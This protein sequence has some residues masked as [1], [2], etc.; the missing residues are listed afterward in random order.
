MEQDANS[1]QKKQLIDWQHC[2]NQAMGNKDLAKELL[3]K[4]LLDLPT[5]LANIQQAFSTPDYSRL[6]FHVHSLHG[7]LCYTGLPL[8]KEATVIL[9]SALKQNARKPQK[10][11]VDELVNNLVQHIEDVLAMPMLS[12]EEMA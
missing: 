9:E 11:L 6:E 3:D 4:I 1:M 7:I 5:N 10:L 2:I 8:L 12:E